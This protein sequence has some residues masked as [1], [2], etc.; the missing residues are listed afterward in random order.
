MSKSYQTHSP[1]QANPSNNTLP[2]AP[3]PHRNSR[4]NPRRNDQVSS[5]LKQTKQTTL[6]FRPQPVSTPTPPPADPIA[7]DSARAPIEIISLADAS[8][9]V[10]YL[11]TSGK[12]NRDKTLVR[13]VVS[14][15]RNAADFANDASLFVDACHACGPERC[16]DLVGV[17]GM[18]SAYQAFG[19]AALQKIY[20]DAFKKNPAAKLVQEMFPCAVDQ[21]DV[22]VIIWCCN[23]IN[24]GGLALR[25]LMDKEAKN[26]ISLLPEDYLE[27]TLLP[28]LLKLIHPFTDVKA[29]GWF[30][31]LDAVGARCPNPQFLQP[32]LCSLAPSLPITHDSV[33]SFVTLCVKAD[34]FIA[35]ESGR[36]RITLLDAVAATQLIQKLA[37]KVQSEDSFSRTQCRAALAHIFKDAAYVLIPGGQIHAAALATAIHHT[38]FPMETFRDCIC[39]F[40]KT[41]VREN[42]GARPTPWITNEELYTANCGCTICVHQL[43]PF[44]LGNQRD[45][46]ISGAP[47][48]L[49]HAAHQLARV[50]WTSHVQ[51]NIVHS[52][53][54]G[55][56]LMLSKSAV[57]MQMAPWRARHAEGVRILTML[58]DEK[59]QRLALGEDAEWVYGTMD[60]TTRPPPKGVTLGLPMKIITPRT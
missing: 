45:I 24:D 49:Y 19:W 42:L 50:R 7:T 8:L 29:L 2:W 1:F 47:D 39:K 25:A 14:Q 3:L 54:R 55:S 43:V 46:L 44:L 6:R 9:R 28:R 10:D 30:A 32:Y 23:C 56:Q 48:Q 37:S 17:E 51:V 38:P 59:Q 15:I 40:I 36:L 33:L 21:Q 4:P 34:A 11:Q 41:Y 53:L 26:W 27:K 13:N 35:L 5:S 20:K 31:I 18:V 16:I 60:G 58:G 22:D 57:L 12:K 52:D